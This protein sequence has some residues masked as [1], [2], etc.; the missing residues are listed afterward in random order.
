MKG[1]GV[2]SYFARSSK[3]SKN[4]E[5]FFP[6][7]HLNVFEFPNE[8]IAQEKFEIMDKALQSDG[9]FC[10]GKAPQIL[11]INKNEVFLLSTRA[12]MFRGYIEDY[13]KFIKSYK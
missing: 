6:D 7:F 13:A 12:E 3:P 1:K 10:N 9:R 2:R 11:V 8:K 5:D 4:T